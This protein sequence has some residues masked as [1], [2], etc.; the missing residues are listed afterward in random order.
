MTIPDTHPHLLP[1]FYHPLQ[2]LT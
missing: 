1:R 2:S